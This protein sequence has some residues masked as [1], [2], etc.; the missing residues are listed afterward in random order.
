MIAE[1]SALQKQ[2]AMAQQQFALG[3]IKQSAQAEQSMADMLI[4]NLETVT[5]SSRG[6]NLNTQA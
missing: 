4:K 2:I 5:A 1:I 6:Q 3:A